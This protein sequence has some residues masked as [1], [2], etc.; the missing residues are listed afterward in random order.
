MTRLVCGL[1]SSATDSGLA[2]APLSQ[3]GFYQ[4]TL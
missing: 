3:T 1:S 4:T 2:T